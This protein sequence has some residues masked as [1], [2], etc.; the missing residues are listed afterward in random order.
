MI[1]F[2]RNICCVSFI[3]EKN[4]LHRQSSPLKRN[5]DDVKRERKRK[6]RSNCRQMERTTSTTKT[7]I[8]KTCR[9]F[10]H[11]FYLSSVII[12]RQHHLHFISGMRDVVT[13][14]FLLFVLFFSQTLRRSLYQNP[15]SSQFFFSSFF[16]AG[17]FIAHIQIKA[18]SRGSQFYIL[19]IIEATEQNIDRRRVLHRMPEKKM[20]KNKMNAWL[21]MT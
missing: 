16:S 2:E 11:L 19:L 6:L 12:F 14:F 17:F 18:G 21:V 3:I 1:R 15:N 20:V 13:F 7:N 5:D 4:I 8:R 9:C 10:S